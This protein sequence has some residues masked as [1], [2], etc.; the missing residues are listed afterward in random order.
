[1]RWSCTLKGHGLQALL[2]KLCLAATVY[3]LWRLR[4]DLC[5]RNTP[6]TKEA[7]VAQIQWEV[8]SRLMFRRK[9]ERSAMSV[10]L[11]QIWKL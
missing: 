5:H 6:R 11:V 4:N 10:R 8:R 1:V 2:C 3:H 9:I 7:L